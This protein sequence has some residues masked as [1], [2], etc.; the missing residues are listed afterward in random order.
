MDH[1]I[2]ND[3][4][5]L[6]YSFL[7]YTESI[8]L[9]LCSKSSYKRKEMMD[10]YCQHIQPHGK[11][12]LYD[13]KTKFQI[14]ERNYKE[15]KLDGI[16]RFWYNNGILYHECNY[17]EGKL[18]GTQ[19]CWYDNGFLMYIHNYKKEKYEGIQQEFYVNG[20]IC[21]TKSYKNGICDFS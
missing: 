17:K 12:E 2:C 18:E 14:H 21:F 5:P 8:Y 4:H 7:L 6:M 9:Q 11:I 3:L 19:K 10:K 1:L 20:E 13:K 16:E 15:G